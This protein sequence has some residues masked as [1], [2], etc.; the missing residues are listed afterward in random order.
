MKNLINF[1]K[2]AYKISSFIEKAINQLRIDRNEYDIS[3]AREQ[4]Y[5]VLYILVC[6]IS[7]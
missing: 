2:N 5:P 6:I 1:L 3:V 7:K 4:G